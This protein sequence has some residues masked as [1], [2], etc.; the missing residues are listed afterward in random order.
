MA[1][2]RKNCTECNGSGRVLKHMY[3]SG[4]VARSGHSAGAGMI[5]CP[6]CHGSGKRD[7]YVSDA[8]DGQDSDFETSWRT[9]KIGFFAFLGAFIGYAIYGF[10][11][12]SVI[13]GAAIGAIVAQVFMSFRVG[14]YILFTAFLGFVALVIYAAMT[15]K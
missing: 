8:D 14:R 10:T 7:V 2:E 5:S 11:V 1:I 13:G 4:T 12:P 9:F 6:R 15:A 3:D